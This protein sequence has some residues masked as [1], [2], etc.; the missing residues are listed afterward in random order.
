MLILMR[1]CGAGKSA[2]DGGRQPCTVRVQY[3]TTI[4]IMIIITIIVIIII[5]IIIVW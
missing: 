1:L 2:A 4:M 3:S 5:I